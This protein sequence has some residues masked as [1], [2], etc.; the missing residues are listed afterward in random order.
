[1]IAAGPGGEA[2]TERGEGMPVGRLWG[3]GV[4]WDQVRE[5][6]AREAH[7]PMG[8]ERAVT[9]TPWTDPDAVRRALAETREGRQALALGA[10]PPWGALADVRPSLERVRTEGTLLDGAELR[11]LVPL[12]DAAGRLRAYGRGVASVAPGLATQFSHL[13]ILTPLHELLN[14]SL[15]TEGTL[16]DTASPRLRLI[17]RKIR[18][19]RAEIV[20]SLETLFQTQGADAIFQDRFVTIRHGRYVMPVRAES[21]SR[22]RGIVHD[23]SQSGAT[24]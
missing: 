18:D 10:P 3:R 19:L 22:F 16:T 4:D 1:M 21:L 12:L 15:T 6:L 8:Q 13:P 24:L 20:K 5:L 7:T 11:L 23:R 17:R 14:R 9:L 2:G